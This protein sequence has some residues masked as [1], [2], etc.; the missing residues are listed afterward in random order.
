MHEKAVVFCR[1]CGRPVPLEDC[2]SDD[3]GRI[4]HENCYAAV[5]K[6]RQQKETAAG[7]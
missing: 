3:T 7:S 2:K 5:I 4:V 1:I 6:A